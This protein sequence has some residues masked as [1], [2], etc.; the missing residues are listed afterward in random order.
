ME[1]KVRVGLPDVGVD[2]AG[3]AEEL[4]RGRPGAAAVNRPAGLPQGSLH[5]RDERPRGQSR[6]SPV[7]SIFNRSA[8]P[9]SSHV[10]TNAGKPRRSSIR[11]RDRRASAKAAMAS[12]ADASSSRSRR[13][14]MV[15]RAARGVLGSLRAS[16]AWR[17]TAAAAASPNRKPATARPRKSASI[18]NCRMTSS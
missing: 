6:S 1:G 5:G 2:F 14:R 11:P 17:S 10:G 15:C 3:C 13:A 18:E 4:R 7:L 9:N 16:A 8:T 12:A